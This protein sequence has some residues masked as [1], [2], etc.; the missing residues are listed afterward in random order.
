MKPPPFDYHAP[1][2]L[3]EA[4]SLLR[5]AGD[6]G[7]LLAGGQSLVPLMNLRLARP[8]VLID[9][10]RV[11]GLDGIEA[12]GEVRI[13]AMARHGRIQ[14]S[15]ELQSRVPMLTEAMRHVGHPA[16]R[17]RGTL[18]G[19][20]AHADPSAEA[21]LVALALG[22][23]LIAASSGGNR[24]IPGDGFFDG[25]FMT[26]LADDEVLTEIVFPAA[27]AG[28]GWGFHE[29]ARAHGDFAL[30]AA[31]AVAVVED[32]RLR[33]VRLAIA[34]AADR[35]TRIG[36]AESALEGAAWDEKARAHLG[37]VVRD[38]VSPASDS[39]ASADYRK[40]VAAALAVRALD[41]ATRQA[42]AG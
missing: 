10:R 36:A 22:A 23:E 8:A 12:N 27:P 15:A 2:S 26:V 28:S 37:G 38:A 13:G 1:D 21:P 7:K 6:E 5:D 17:N 19:S 34:G 4:K 32:G 33:D 29:V 39:H 20:I 30:V 9:L 25:P 3:D 11:P 40:S 18:G 42:I 41:D 35:P 31:A 24:S 16:I 14:H